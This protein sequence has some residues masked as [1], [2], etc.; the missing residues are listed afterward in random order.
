MTVTEFL[1]SHVPFL[2]GL[3]A[4]QARELAESAQQLQFSNGQTVLFKG[5]TV[6]GLYVVATGKVSVWV[7][8]DKNKPVTQVAELVPGDV[9]GETSIL[10]MGTAGATIKASEDGTLLFVLPHDAFRGIIDANEALRARAE[11]LI[12]ARKKKNLELSLP[13]P[14]GSAAV[15]VA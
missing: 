8:P 10:E 2:E 13:R 4:E 1:S 12:A 15:A 5:T 9:F 6:D 3:S 14:E 7:K 11:A